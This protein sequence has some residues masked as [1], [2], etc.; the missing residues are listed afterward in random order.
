MLNTKKGSDNI[1]MYLVERYETKLLSKCKSI[2][3]KYSVV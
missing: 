3:V 1:Q 2:I